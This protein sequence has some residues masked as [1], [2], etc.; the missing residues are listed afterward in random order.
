MNARQLLVYMMDDFGDWID[1][2]Y[3]VE[4]YKILDSGQLWVRFTNEDQETSE[5]IVTVE[6]V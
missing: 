3:W 2:D 5:F 1:G 6:S 4:E